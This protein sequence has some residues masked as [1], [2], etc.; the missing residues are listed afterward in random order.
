RRTAWPHRAADAHGDGRRGHRMNSRRELLSLL[1][2]A[3]AW[4]LAARAQQR[5][6]VRRIGALMS[7]SSD[8]SQGQARVMAFVQGLQE[9]GWII[10]RNVRIETR[11]GAGDGERY[12][13]YT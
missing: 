11:W 4:L 8:G 13:K 12:R 2:G 7:S 1:G 9:A 6:Q 10:G 3:A 5:E